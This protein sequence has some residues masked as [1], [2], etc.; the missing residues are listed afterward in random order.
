MSCYGTAQLFELDDLSPQQ[1]LRRIE[2]AVL[3]LLRNGSIRFSGP[4]PAPNAR[5]FINGAVRIFRSERILK[6]PSR[7]VAN[8]LIVL[9]YSHRVLSERKTLTIREMYYRNKTMKESDIG[10]KN[11]AQCY[12]TIILC[13]HILGVTR[14][15]LG[16]VTSPKG[17]MAGTSDASLSIVQPIP[18]FQDISELQH[19]FDSISS[20]KPMP[21]FLLIVEKHTILHRL[22]QSSFFRIFP[23]VA[24]TGKGFPDL[25]TRRFA[26]FVQS[27]FNFPTFGLCDLNPHGFSLISTFEFGSL[28][29]AGESYRYCV[30][31]IQILGLSV[32]DARYYEELCK[33]FGITSKFSQCTKADV[34]CLSGLKNNVAF[35]K[36]SNLLREIHIFEQEGIK[37]DLDAFEDFGD[38]F[39]FEEFIA[40]K[41]F[42]L[43][44]PEVYPQESQCLHSC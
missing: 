44:H 30:P 32:S 39:L 12:R 34:L 1:V 5:V 2:N 28:R 18:S 38:G 14:S 37:L 9:N 3:E 19:I 8:V 17:L 13:T 15:S 11:E 27:Y 25:H 43:M 35:Q 41:I 16:L 7:I 20:R 23:C 22:V 24:L 36:H 10:F 4:N 40:R 31:N 21:T 33:E 29:F 42:Q 26:H 6:L